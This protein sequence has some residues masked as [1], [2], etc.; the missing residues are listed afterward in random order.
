MHVYLT[1]KNLIF[2]DINSKAV[3]FLIIVITLVLITSFFS[4]TVAPVSIGEMYPHLVPLESTWK[5][6][7]IKKMQ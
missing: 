5:G 6:H 7:V 2:R 4:L 1:K 3:K